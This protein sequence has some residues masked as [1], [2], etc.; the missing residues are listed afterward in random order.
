MNETKERELRT[1]AAR[2]RIHTIRAMAG[3]GG[4][5][6]GG[7]MSIADVLAVLYGSVLRYDPHG[8]R[9][10]DRDRLVLSKGHC[11]PALYAALALSGFFPLDMLKTLNQGGT[12]LPSHC[13][14]IKTPGIDMTTG[15]LGQGVSCAAGIAYALKKK[16]SAAHVFSIV[17]DGELQEGQ[18]WEAVQFAAHQQLS[19]FT[20]IVDYNHLQ[21]DG[22]LDSICRPFNPE[23]K[24][25]AFGLDARSAP[26]YD[27]RA[28]HDALEWAKA[29][30]GCCAVI[31]D[32]FKGIGCEFAEK[33]DFCHY[34]QFGE[35]E[36][37]RAETEILRRLELN[38]VKGEN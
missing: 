38:I 7:S 32:T 6:I 28:V 1:L 19:N 13:D 2:I 22:T 18:V 17:G 36:A 9:W 10:E 34:M 16:G 4:G 5:H 8:P 35:A 30:P 15:S 12:S 14:R 26:G 27:V 21:L 29:A 11:G 20:I 3:A 37:A 33:A 31:L 25:R 23:N 24:F